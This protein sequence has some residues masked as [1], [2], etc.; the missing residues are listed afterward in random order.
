MKGTLVGKK[1]QLKQTGEV[2]TIT[3]VINRCLWVDMGEGIT[4]SGG[5]SYWKVIAK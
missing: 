1:A 5:I 4:L 2:G 3:K